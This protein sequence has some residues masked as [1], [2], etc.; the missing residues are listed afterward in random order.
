[1]SKKQ[2]KKKKTIMKTMVDGFKYFLNKREL[3]TM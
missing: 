1:M 3:N 2:F